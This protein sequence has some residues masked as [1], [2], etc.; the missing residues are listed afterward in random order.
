MAYTDIRISYVL[1]D[2][3]DGELYTIRRETLRKTKASF[4]IGELSYWQA[5]SMYG[6]PESALY[7]HKTGKVSTCKRGPGTVLT[8]P[9]E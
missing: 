5:Q 2:L 9:E 4:R 1:C 7:D 6:I 3:L 8:D